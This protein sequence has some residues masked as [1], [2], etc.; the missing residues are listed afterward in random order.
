LSPQAA[1]RIQRLQTF[2]VPCNDHESACLANR[3]TDGLYSDERAPPTR[4]AARRSHPHNGDDNQVIPLPDNRRQHR[5]HLDHPRNRAPETTEKAMPERLL[6]FPDFVIPEVF[7]TAGHFGAVKA[8][9]TV[10]PQLANRLINRLAAIIVSSPGHFAAYLLAAPGNRPGPTVWQASLV[11][12][13]LPKSSL[14]GATVFW[15]SLATSRGPSSD[16]VSLPAV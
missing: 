5:R 8:A 7:D 4:P 2:R 1:A 3:F 10:N 13:Q 16:R 6:R 11:N 14:P 12:S 15:S 9:R